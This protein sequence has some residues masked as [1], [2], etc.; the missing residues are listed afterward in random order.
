MNF[1]NSFYETSY[2]QPCSSV[3]ALNMVNVEYIK[4]EENIDYLEQL[5]GFIENMNINPLWFDS[6]SDKN[7]L[8]LLQVFQLAITYSK[9]LSQSYKAEI[10]GWQSK[11]Q[12]QAQENEEKIKNIKENKEK[13]RRMKYEYKKR[14]L[15]HLQRVYEMERLMER[16]QVF[17]FL[18]R[19]RKA[20]GALTS[21]RHILIRSFTPMSIT[22]L[23][24]LITSSLIP[25]RT[26]FRTLRTITILLRKRTSTLKRQTS[27][28]SKDSIAHNH[29]DSIHH[30]RIAI[31]QCSR[32]PTTS[33]L[34]QVTP[35]KAQLFPSTSSLP[36][37]FCRDWQAK[38]G[39]DLRR[40]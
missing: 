2:Q 23:S 10:A 38:L 36:L 32:I 24:T 16:Q 11:N 5:C 27:I 39:P 20:S 28:T 34:R 22:S 29:K 33:N 9:N 4:S 12:N 37:L 14:K 19:R 6:E 31:M 1:G 35:I 13:V 15:A 21:V 26:C 7:K 18:F 17:I 8:K 40:L 25:P 30:S 3:G